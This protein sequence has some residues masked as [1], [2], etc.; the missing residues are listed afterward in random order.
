MGPV[1]LVTGSTDGIGRA[2]AIEIARQGARVIIHGRSRAKAY[3][4]HARARVIGE[5]HTGN[6]KY[7]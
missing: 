4:L 5:R 6:V 2:T 1:I 3:R 7:C